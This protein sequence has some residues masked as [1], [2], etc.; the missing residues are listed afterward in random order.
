MSTYINQKTITSAKKDYIATGTKYLQV[1]QD[2]LSV[3]SY[4]LHFNSFKVYLYL[5]E[6]SRGYSQTISYNAVNSRFKMSKAS[7][8]RGMADLEK[9]GF[10]VQTGKDQ[11]V[12]Y[13]DAEG[14][15]KVPDDDE[16]DCD[17]D[18]EDDEIEIEDTKMKSKSTPTTK[19]KSTWVYDF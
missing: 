4:Y 16:L 2:E 3:A 13:P 12:F 7:Y 11:W 17:I 19:P 14:R 9:L 6:A 18:D 15:L 10:L 5:A 1:G 8:K